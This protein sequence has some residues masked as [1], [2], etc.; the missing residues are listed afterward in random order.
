MNPVDH[1][2]GGGNHQHIG[3]ASTIARGAVSGQKVGLIAARRVR[4]LSH[5]HSST[6]HLPVRGQSANLG[7]YYFRLVCFAVRSKSRRFKC[8][9]TIL[10]QLLLCH[11]LLP[12]SVDPSRTSR[13]KGAY[14][15]E[16]TCMY[17]VRASWSLSTSLCHVPLVCE[18]KTK[19]FTCPI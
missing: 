11:T 18:Y 12:I 5:I 19:N 15:V 14:E 7:Y 2:H 4:D 8:I 6:S 1:P 17:R 10:L 9:A 13:R 16:S 3:K